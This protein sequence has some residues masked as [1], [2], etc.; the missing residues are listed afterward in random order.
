LKK[1]TFLIPFV[2]LFTGCFSFSEQANQQP[3]KAEKSVN[4]QPL[5]PKI[6]RIEG[7]EEYKSSSQQNIVVKP[8]PALPP[9]TPEEKKELDE[10]EAMIHND[11]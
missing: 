4:T 10:I 9:E 8:A 5:K 3:V 11:Q 7:T 6:E 2:T 1:T